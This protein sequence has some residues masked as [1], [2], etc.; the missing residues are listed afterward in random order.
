MAWFEV[1]A[2][3]VDGSS[4]HPRCAAEQSGC[5]RLNAARSGECVL[6]W[7]AMSDGRGRATRPSTQTLQE[8]HLA[9]K[10]HPW[11]PY[12]VRHAV[13]Q[14]SGSL[15]VVAVQTAQATASGLAIF[16][17]R[18]QHCALAAVP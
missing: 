9:P 6:H 15:E 18:P 17:R 7:C 11:T 12:I 3:G 5:M 16:G 13:V 10:P 1:P 4:S 2:G 14:R 8:H